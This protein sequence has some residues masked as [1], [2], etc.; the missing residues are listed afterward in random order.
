MSEQDIIRAWKDEEYRNSL[1]EAQRAQ[2]P[3]NPVGAVELPDSDLDSVSGGTLGTV[4]KAGRAA[5]KRRGDI[6]NGAQAVYI[7]ARHCPSGGGGG[8]GTQKSSPG[9]RGCAM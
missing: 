2:L 5:W 6:V 7:S 8:V 1:S 4:V 3:D 9:P